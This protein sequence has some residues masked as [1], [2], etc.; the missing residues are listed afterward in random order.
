MA[1]VSP[2]IALRVLYQP[3]AVFGELADSAPSAGSVFFKVALWL[4][5][6]PPIC[7]YIGSL[8]FGWQLGAGEPVFVEPGTMVGVALAYFVTLIFGFVSVAVVAQWMAQ[9]Y[10]ADSSWA[11]GVAIISYTATP[12]FLAGLL[13]LYPSLW[14]DLLV[15]LAVVAG[16][17]V[18]WFLAPPSSDEQPGGDTGS[19]VAVGI[20]PHGVWL[21]GTW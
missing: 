12:F 13:G 1:A 15:G 21:G 3:S 6:L 10:G 4:L 11:K 7:A 19:S 5:L 18:W 8:T 17:G 2:S 14:V 9:T 20:N 16:G